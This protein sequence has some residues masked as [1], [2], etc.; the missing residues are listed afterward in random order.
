MNEFGSAD[1][2]MRVMER[3]IDLADSSARVA[4]PELAAGGLESAKDRKTGA[5]S[6]V[7]AGAVGGSFGLIL[8]V[9][10]ESMLSPAGMHFVAPSLPLMQAEFAGVA[11][12]DI[13]VPMVVTLPGLMIAMCAPFMGALGDRIG[14][15]PLL[16]WSMVAYMI[17]GILPYWLE[18]LYAIIGARFLFGIAESALAVCGTPL[19]AAGFLA[20]RRRAMISGR[21]AF[22]GLS[23]MFLAMCGGWAA[24]SGWRTAYLLYLFAAV[25]FL[26]VLFFVPRSLTIVESSAAGKQPRQLWAIYGLNFVYGT[27]IAALFVYSAFLLKE[28]GIH[29][30]KLAGTLSG[31]AAFT[32]VAASLLFPFISRRVSGRAL[33]ILSFLLM[34][35]GCATLSGANDAA[36]V[37]AG[38]VLTATGMGLFIPTSTDMLLHYC[39]P[40]H[41]GRATGIAMMALYLGNFVVP[42][43]MT[44]LTRS[45]SSIGQGYVLLSV[46]YVIT[47]LVAM[48]LAKAVFAIPGG[49]GDRPAAH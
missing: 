18:S 19:I 32:T 31:A 44:A 47:A 17:I 15:R 41:R 30:P 3:I 8:A 1:L 10:A 20:G 23:S 40:Q 22:I 21:V 5:T 34:A 49:S 13:L 9:F 7:A 42:F 29:T 35:A 46:V 38:L 14:V 11:Q 39:L 6:G 45:G 36:L 4:G 16:L 12:A 48:W 43:S 25:P 24:Q 37:G 28:L 26:L 2:K 33:M 27:G